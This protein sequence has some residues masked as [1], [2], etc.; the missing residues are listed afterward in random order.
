MKMLNVTAAMVF[1]REFKLDLGEKQS[2]S[3]DAVINF[4]V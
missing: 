3:S 1:D 4:L 2:C